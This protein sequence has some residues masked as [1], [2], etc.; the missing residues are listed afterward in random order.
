MASRPNHL[1]QQGAAGSLDRIV[2]VL[3]RALQKNAR[4]PNKELAELAGLAPSSC[5]E[6]L[7]RLRARGVLQGFHAEADLAAL[8]R[9]TQAMIA[10][11]LAVHS[12]DEIDAFYEHVLRLPETLAAFHV[13]GGDD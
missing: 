3:I 2:W 13:S 6:R 7:R 9:G 1:R 10:V 11:R 12:R 4:V 5:L 8:G